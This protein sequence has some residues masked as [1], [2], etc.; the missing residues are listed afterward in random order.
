MAQEKEVF[1]EYVISH[2]GSEDV[3]KI[4]ANRWNYSP[5]IEDNPVTMGYVIDKLVENPQVQRIIFHQKKNFHYDYE[6]TQMLLDIAQVYH[7]LV[8]T[9]KILSLV[10]LGFQEQF[11]AFYGEKLTS[12]QDLL[13]RLLRTDPVGCFVETKR[14]LREEKIALGKEKNNELVQARTS[15]L[16]LLH[17]ISSLLEKTKLISLVKDSLEGYQLQDRSIY[18]TILRARISPDFMLTQL[19]SKQPLDGEEVDV[20]SLGE[21][22]GVTIFKVPGDVKLLYHLN[23]RE[24]QLNEDE[25]TLLELARTVLAEHKPREEE[26]LEP[27]KIRTT[28][29]HIGRDLLQELADT[30]G[31]QLP[32]EKIEELARIL[33]RYTVGF[34][35]LEV[36]LQDVKIQDIVVNSPIGGSPIFIVHQEY[37]ECSTN[38]IPNRDEADSWATKFRL[39]S[40]RPLD[41]AN[42][43]LD[44][45]L[46]VPGARSRVAIMSSPLS[47]HGLAF[48]LRRHRD[49]PWT[50][51]LFMKYK[52]MDSMAAGLISFL[53]DGARTMLVAGTR[54]SGK[55]SILGA[56]MVE[57]MRKYRMVTVEDTPELPVETLRQLGY[58]IQDM[59]VRSALT[60]GGVEMSAE[61]GIRTSLRL[62]DSSLIVGEVRSLE[63]K[64]LWEAMRVGA[65]A[66]VVAGTIHGADPYGVYDRVVNDLGIPKTSFKATDIIL[67]ANPI[68]TADG[69]K[70]SKRLIQITEVRKHWENDPLAE[71]G[72]VD[73]MKYNS[74][75][76]MIEV[77]NDLLQGESEVLK[78]IASNVREWA[79]NWDAIWENI[80]LR[81][82][83]K[84]AL[85]QYADR[86]KKDSLLEAKFIV[87]SND[88]FHRISEQVREETGS[89]DSKR[90]FFSWQEWLKREIKSTII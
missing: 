58:N 7:H 16:Q 37:G 57:I 87:Q 41:E 54:S 83:V 26:F 34:G 24:F 86:L 40:G 82:K 2:E 51:P 72:F 52:M 62:G 43:V 75:T 56:M 30:K 14:L 9:R 15:Y 39:L 22:V 47:P 89:L 74:K 81:A 69:L 17:Y 20:Y 36:L 27:G 35:L 77:T 19:M 64:A 55:T 29:F 44:T 60:T 78:S 85:V 25:Y 5:S 71:K 70:K 53:I 31:I 42:P 23:P 68:T 38:I 63:A 21:Q 4:D 79:G 46:V 59:K 10:H 49:E 65:L 90:I 88:W 61:E 73:L 32:Y 12:L 3:L 80:V 11:A 45:E 13:F 76:D 50:L 28:F 33:V 18:R 84:E 1:K 66:N 48:A 67:V 8:S 6:A